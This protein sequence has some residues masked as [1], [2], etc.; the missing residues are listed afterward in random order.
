MATETT[1]VVNS[2]RHG[3][4]YHTSK[5]IE[6]LKAGSH[7]DI[8]TRD[9]MAKIIDRDCSTGS[10][11]YGNVNSA[12][13]IVERESRIIWRWSREDA[14]WK[15]LGDSEQVAESQRE[16]KR[17]RKHAKRSLTVAAAVQVA[18]LNEQE[19]IAHNVNVSVAGAVVLFGGGAT[20]KRLEKVPSVREPR[21][22]DI[23]KLFVGE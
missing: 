6:H 22:G 15:C 7:G 9:Q 16:I 17:S 2:F 1:D 5:A 14:A 21:I 3:L 19:R 11:G 12:I 18:K 20:R 13:R 10:L 4:C 23:E 8:V